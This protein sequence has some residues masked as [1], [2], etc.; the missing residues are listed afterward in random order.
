MARHGQQNVEK[1]V[2]QPVI[3]LAQV[4]QFVDQI[5]ERE[6]REKCDENE[7]RRPIDFAREVATDR[8]HHRLL[9]PEPTRRR[10]QNKNR[11]TSSMATCTTHQPVPNPS[12]P[13][14]TQA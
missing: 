14:D 12:L 5:E 3:P 10:R 1:R 4:T 11:S 8:E 7:Q 6:E 2:L 9:A 13:E